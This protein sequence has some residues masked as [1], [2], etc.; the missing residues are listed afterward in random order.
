MPKKK[1]VEPKPTEVEEATFIAKQP[2]KEKPKK[3]KK[4]SNEIDEIFA[5]KKRKKP[6]KNG[7]GDEKSKSSEKKTKKKKTRED[8]EGRFTDPPV[9]SR[10]KTEDGFNIYAEDELGINSSNGGGTPLCP[11]DCECCF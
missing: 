8:R 5:G 10:K 9:K 2:K 7:N 1:S 4:P 3:K 6:E 11:F